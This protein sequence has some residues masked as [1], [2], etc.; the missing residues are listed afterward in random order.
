MNSAKPTQ[1]RQGDVFLRWVPSMHPLAK[2]V[3]ASPNQLVLA[4]GELTGH[5]HVIHSDGTT[6][7][8]HGSQV[9]IQVGPSGA[10]LTHQ[11]HASIPIPPGIYEVIQQRQHSPA[12]MDHVRD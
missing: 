5:A 1:F 8:R 7:H 3:D 11:E 4:R 2:K 6:L 10:E 9:W 12:G